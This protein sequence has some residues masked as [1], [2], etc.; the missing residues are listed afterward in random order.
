[1]ESHQGTVNYQ[2]IV[3]IGTSF[4]LTLH[5]GK[6]HFKDNLIF[7]D[8]LESSAILEELTE[9]AEE[10][11]F[12]NEAPP[13]PNRLQEDISSEQKTILIID[14]N[15][16]IRDYIRQIFESK[17]Q[18]LEAESGDQGL[19]MVTQ[20][21][22]D[23][24]ISDVVMPNLNGLEL[25]KLI[26]EDPSLNHIP[27]VL[28]TASTSP[29]IKLK[30]IGYGA[31]DYISKPFEKELLIARIE[32]LLKIRNDLQKYFYNEITLK[33]GNLK[34]SA[35]YKEFLDRCIEIVEKHMTDPNFGIQTLAEEIGMSRSN[36]YIKIKLISGQS[37]NSFIRFIR[38][39]KA[40]EIFVSTA[41]TVQ[42]TT[43]QVGIKD[44]R[45]FR[46]QFYKL[47]NMNPSDYIKK[48]RKT[49]TGKYS[50]N[51]S[52]IKAKELK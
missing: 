10:Q 32:G 5:K 4:E 50:L 45:Y 40:A 7:D 20:Y 18:L 6:V 21:L 44:A 41:L 8:Q 34:I 51:K 11:V 38:L 14:D 19:H 2:S 12:K 49:F 28:L 23:V 15:K 48:Y 37:A 27:V 52:L 39:R 22:P 1:M 13:I 42:E 33:S 3:G 29:D 16:Q 24:V 36:L 17:F 9:G 25:C 26:K 30:G 47:F 31:D 35:E 46:E 43:F